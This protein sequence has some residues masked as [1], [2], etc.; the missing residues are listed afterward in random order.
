MSKVP[1]LLGT[2]VAGIIGVAMVSSASASQR[3]SSKSS[4]P[5]APSGVDL[6]ELAKRSTD[7]MVRQDIAALRKDV[8]QWKQASDP[9]TAGAL[10]FTLEQAVA[11]EQL[12]EAKLDGN[13]GSPVLRAFAMRILQLEGRAPRLKLWANAWR[14]VLPVLAA[15][16]DAKARGISEVASATGAAPN[17]GAEADP[18]PDAATMALI[19]AAVKSQDPKKIR[20]AADKL[21]AL[22]FP[23]AAKDLRQMAVLIESG[24]ATASPS[25]TAPIIPPAATPPVV[26]APEPALPSSSGSSSVGLPS[27]PPPGAPLPASSSSRVAIVHRGEGMSQVASR[28]LGSTAEGL[29]RW[30]EMRAINP[31]F[32]SDKK[33]NPIL[34]PGDALNVPPSWVTKPGE[35][36]LG[37]SSGPGQKPVID[38]SGTIASSSTPPVAAPTAAALQRLIVV[39]KGEG[40]AQV[41]MRQRKAA[42]TDADRKRLRDFNVPP[43]KKTPDGS[44]LILNPGDKLRIPPEWPPSVEEVL[45]GNRRPMT[46]RQLRAARVALAQNFGQDDSARL[47]QFQRAERIEPS[48]HYGPATAMV[49]AHRFGFVP[50]LPRVWGANE[51]KN[52]LLFARSMFHMARRDPQRADEFRRL[53]RRAEGKL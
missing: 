47:A 39:K 2:A 9:E 15:A 3:G 13:N 42:F 36:I 26:L 14:S 43:F 31:L 6:D 12:V 41:A 23:E 21:D 53:A 20:D 40:V 1:L 29:K 48:G 5:T 38:T 37:R 45:G 24:Q 33:G 51:R 10:S 28:V 11:G 25:A 8:A 35:T 34:Q 27:A 18:Q 50:P 52:R 49:L 7:D 44:G 22:G 32:K 30:R 4:S 17:T 16:L 19:L 46:L